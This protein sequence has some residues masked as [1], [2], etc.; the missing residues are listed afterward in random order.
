ME[1][2]FIAP[3]ITPYSRSGEIG[4]VCAALPKALRGGG[5]K[6][7]VISP[8]WPGIDASARG[9]ARRLS[10]V[11]IELGGRRFPCVL[12][13]GRTTG[14]VELVFVAQPELFAEG[15]SGGDDAARLRAAVG[16]SLAAAQVA[17]TREPAPEVVHAH[18]WFAAA[19]LPLVKA[20]RP[21]VALLLSLHDPAQQGRLAPAATDWLPAALTQLLGE[22][23][24]R[25]LLRAGIAAAQR[26]VSSSEAELQLL[27]GSTYGLAD[28][29]GA[30]GKLLAIANGLDAARWNPLTDPLLPARFDPVELQGKARCKDQ[31][32]FELELP[33]RPELPLVACVGQLTPDAG[34][35]LLARALPQL[36]Q[37]ELQLVVAGGDAELRQLMTAHA[38][39]H[40]ERLRAIAPADERSVHRAIAAADLL[41]VP[42]RDPGYPDLHLC[43]QRYGALPIAP[44]HGAIADAVVDCDAQLTTGTGFLFETDDAADLAAALGR[45]LAAFERAK[46]FEALRRRAMKLD[47]SWERSARRYEH[48]YR[49]LRGAS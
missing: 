10:G 23:E 37:A 3:E 1:L 44:R 39:R 11:E 2:L 20:A 15:P 19:A 25:S 16:L 40:E 28:A 30:N 46:P 7:T 17:V 27:R 48:Q 47:V 5:H 45:A 18:G 4:D 33:V 49:T 42:A 14:G 35:G 22:G 9:L 6:V 13:D 21:E 34:G 41:L 38:A 36:L 43:G 12:H 32:Q 31:L 24:Q 26:V 8:L 29:L